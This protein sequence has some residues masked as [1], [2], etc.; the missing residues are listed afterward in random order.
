MKSS[1]AYLFLLSVLA[2]TLLMLSVVLLS[3]STAEVT[4]HKPALRNPIIFSGSPLQEI[5]DMIYPKS[6]YIAQLGQ[7]LEEHAFIVDGELP[8][9]Y[10]ELHNYLD[11]SD[12]ADGIEIKVLTWQ[13]D[14]N[15][16][17]CIFFKQDP[18]EKNW[19]AMHKIVCDATHFNSQFKLT[20]D[21]YR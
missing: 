9:F 6:H 19:E 8:D 16:N 15:T 20:M 1:I 12:Y 18:K 2:G 17:L 14:P 3:F 7:P 10:F 5:D 21:V 4:K 11:E 13:K